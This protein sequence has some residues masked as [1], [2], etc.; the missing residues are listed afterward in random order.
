MD[1]IYSHAATCV[2]WIGRER[3]DKIREAVK[4]IKAKHVRSKSCLVIGIFRM[5]TLTPEKDAKL[6][7]VYPID[8]TGP[9][10]GLSR[11]LC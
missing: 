7:N 2:A 1:P 9:D 10:P 5:K 6:F 8:R 3:D 11:R 4:L